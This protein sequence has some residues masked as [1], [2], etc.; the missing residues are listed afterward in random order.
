MNPFH[1]PNFPW[2]LIG[3]SF[4]DGLS[5]EEELKL[6]QW[7]V[8][9]PDNMVKY[10]QLR[11]IWDNSTEDYRLYLMA[12]ED[13]AWDTLRSKLKQPQKTKVIKLHTFRAVQIAAAAVLILFVAGVGYWITTKNNIQSYT[14]AKN[15]QKQVNLK[16][17]TII[18]LDAA[19][20]ITVA[21]GFNKENRTVTMTQGKA[22]FTIE[23]QD[24]LPFIVEM[25]K[26]YVK[27]IG[28]AFDIK[29][30]QNQIM[31]AVTSGVIMFNK[32]NS[33]ENKELKAGSSLIYDIASNNFIEPTVNANQKDTAISLTFNNTPLADVIQLIL[34]KHHKNIKLENA[35]I[36][37]KKLTASLEGIPFDTVLAIICK[38][39][40]LE[41]S[42]ADSTYIL[43]EKR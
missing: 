16:D 29:I 23:H 32:Q 39:L 15:E 19:T 3:G 20:S 31:V 37:K 7:L 22:S 38:S 24:N 33:S 18:L 11:Q 5:T 21:E 36:G 25:G 1:N 40:S 9:D 14:T 26:V 13:E 27:D 28:T 42:L 34:L 35:S 12:N 17:G 30:D 41:Y 10:Q 43:K 2:E 6:Q 4:T 8:S